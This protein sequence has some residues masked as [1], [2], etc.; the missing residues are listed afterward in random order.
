LVK[1]LTTLIWITSGLHAAV[2]FGQYG[3]GGWPPNRPMLLR[4][5]LPKE[6]EVEGM[7]I[8]KFV[9]EMLPDKF[10]MKLAIAVMDLLSRHAPD[11]V[12]L[13]Q[14]SPQKE[15]PLIED[16]EFNSEKV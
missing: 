8:M 13:G 5:F 2:N 7:N 16:H 6:E 15:W 14:T 11:E 4:K 1:A 12:Y 3:Y 10:Q 9:E